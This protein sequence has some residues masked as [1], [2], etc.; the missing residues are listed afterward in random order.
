MSVNQTTCELYY[1]CTIL[2]GALTN[3]TVYVGAYDPSA[4]VIHWYNRMEL[5]TI[6]TTNSLTCELIPSLP[7]SCGAGI[8]VIN[9]VS[10]YDHSCTAL[11]SLDNLEAF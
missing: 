9:A 11:V 6:I 8:R 5:A 3:G 10:S 1:N 4:P 2:N 7:A